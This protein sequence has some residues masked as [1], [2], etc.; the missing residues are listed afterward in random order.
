MDKVKT[1]IAKKPLVLTVCSGKGGVGKSFLVANM[2]EV[3]ARN[4]GAVVIWDADIN[5]PNQHILFGVEPPNRLSEVYNGSIEVTSAVSSLHDN[6]FLLADSPSFSDR[7]S[8]NSPV[9]INTYKELISDNDIDMILIDTSSGGSYE[10][11]QSCSISDLVLVVVT[12]EPT[13]LLDAYGLIKLLSPYVDLNKIVL[14]VNNVIDLED[15]NLISSR[16]N[17]ATN[18]FLN[19]KL[20]VLGFV[21]YDRLVRLSIIRQELFIQKYPTS[22]VTKSLNEL[23]EKIY[24]KIDVNKI[25][26]N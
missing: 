10:L 15:A 9:I 21:P 3:F 7:E 6:L 17:S 13:S 18:K 26:T 25:S 16:M 1:N 12:D 22:E 23:C 4:S 8:F 24:K 14:L 2:A 20:D 19:L 5:F 11:I